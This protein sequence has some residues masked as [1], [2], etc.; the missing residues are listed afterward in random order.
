MIII[1]IIIIVFIVYNKYF[2]NRQGFEDYDSK[3][4][5]CKKDIII[6]DRLKDHIYNMNNYSE[7]MNILHP[8]NVLPYNIDK[9]D[10]Y[11]ILNNYGIKNKKK[12]SK[13]KHELNGCTTTPYNSTKLLKNYD[14]ECDNSFKI[15]P[16]PPKWNNYTNTYNNYH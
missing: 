3:S 14:R 13:Y 4:I 8:S 15:I 5:S 16:Q 7:N 11:N 1:L 2:T 6:N 10:V 12:Q 9:I